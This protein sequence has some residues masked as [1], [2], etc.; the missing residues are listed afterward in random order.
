[1]SQAH[2]YPLT[3]TRAFAAFWAAVLGIVILVAVG[4]APVP[5]VHNAAHDTRHS[6]AFPCH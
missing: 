1:M 3:R 2:V 4:F 5:A 6:F